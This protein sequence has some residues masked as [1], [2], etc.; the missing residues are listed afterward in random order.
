MAQ[1]EEP[2]VSEHEVPA[3]TQVDAIQNTN[4]KIQKIIAF[5]HQR[6][7]CHCQDAKAEIKVVRCQFQSAQMHFFTP[8][9]K[10]RR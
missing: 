9:E 8:P 7:K 2:G 6:E 4:E 1:R 10:I 5:Y 3:Q